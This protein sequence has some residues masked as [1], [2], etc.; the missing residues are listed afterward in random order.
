MT[1]RGNTWIRIE[2]GSIEL[3]LPL[4]R[5]TPKTIHL[6]VDWRHNESTARG[7]SAVESLL[8]TANHPPL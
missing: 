7:S 8:E 1:F 3:L 6:A 4:S 5:G 2:P